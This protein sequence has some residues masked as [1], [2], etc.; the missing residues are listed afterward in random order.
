MS[1][2][3]YCVPPNRESQ[4]YY[5]YSCNIWG[6]NCADKFK[7]SWYNRDHNKYNKC[8]ATSEWG[9][10]SFKANAEVCYK[11]KGPKK[12]GKSTE[13]CAKFDVGT[14]TIGKPYEVHTTTA[15]VAGKTQTGLTQDKGKAINTFKTIDQRLLIGGA[16]V[17]LLL[18][19]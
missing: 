19:R 3:G 10:P 5:K 9:R 6:K 8:L 7:Q 14:N 18:L 12:K 1:Y 15:S 17:L 16:V 13:M 4:T 2:P 11:K